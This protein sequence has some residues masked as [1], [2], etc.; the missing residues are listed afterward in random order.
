MYIIS[1]TYIST[2]CPASFNLVSQ[3]AYSAATPTI[4]L[5]KGL[6]MKYLMVTG[7]KLG[8]LFCKVGIKKKQFMYDIFESD[9]DCNLF[10]SPSNTL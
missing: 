7:N 2:T 10:Q 3:M 4:F 8:S 9:S 5:L 1:H 6:S